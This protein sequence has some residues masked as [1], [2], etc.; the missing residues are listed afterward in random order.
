[1]ICR[2][3]REGESSW[4]SLAMAR[5]LSI[6]RSTMPTLFIVEYACTSP[7]HAVS[8]RFGLHGSPNPTARDVHY[9][10]SMMV[11]PADASGANRKKVIMA[12]FISQLRGIPVT[13]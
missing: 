6:A 3:V 8:R 10:P 7:K 9:N 13:G 1:M 4:F 2:T 5:H 11:E 12:F